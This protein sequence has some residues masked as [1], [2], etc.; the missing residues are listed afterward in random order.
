MS[1]YYDQLGQPISRE[2]WTELFQHKRVAASDHAMS[3]SALKSRIS[4][5]WVGIDHGF[6]YSARPLIFETM[7]FGGPLDEETLRYS[8]LEE[9]VHGH[10]EVATRVCE[11]IVKLNSSV[12]G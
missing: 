7:V 5:V 11:I 9:A 8:T 4:T 6:G 10:H 1:E 12:R 2:R 3:T